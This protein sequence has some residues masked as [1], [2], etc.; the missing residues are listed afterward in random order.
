MRCLGWLAVYLRLIL[1]PCVCVCKDLYTAT[2]AMCMGV[3]NVSL[4]V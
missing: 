4:W 1:C 2:V 3:H